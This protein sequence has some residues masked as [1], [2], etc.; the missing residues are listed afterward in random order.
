MD[1]WRAT[2]KPRETA[3]LLAR[4][5]VRSLAVVAALGSLARSASASDELYEG[6]AAFVGMRSDERFLLSAKTDLALVPFPERDI[7]GGRMNATRVE[8]TLGLPLRGHTV[9]LEQARVQLIR[10]PHLHVLGVERDRLLGTSVGV[11]GLALYVPFRISGGLAD[12]HWALLFVGASAGYRHLAQSFGAQS[13]GDVGFAAP[14]VEADAQASI[15]PRLALRFN[16]GASYLAALGSL[17][18]KGGAGFAHTAPLTLSM[19]LAYDVTS[20]PRL[21]WVA[22]TDVATGEPRF[23]QAV[24]E[25]RRLRFL[26]LQVLF[27]VRPFDTLTT[28][29]SALAVVQLGATYE[30]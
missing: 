18:A 9:G 17:E 30:Y 8:A 22:R 27:Q 15:D 25:G 12:P 5:L 1:G 16:V 21:R 2:S 14:S 13:S 28:M 24:N 29:A 23:V 11:E 6:D 4:L 3:L 7:W 19:A 26:P 20:R 10:W